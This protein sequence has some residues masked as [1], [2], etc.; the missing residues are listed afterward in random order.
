MRN[1]RLQLLILFAAGMGAAQFRESG[2]P[3]L[4]AH[5]EL[6]TVPQMPAR[7]YLFK[8]GRPFRL[9][10]VGA[11]LP[12]R[13]DLFYRERLWRAAADPETL[14]VT[15]N[16]QSHFFLLKGRATF[17]LPAGHYRVEAYRGLFYVPARAEFDI[18]AGE[19][20]RVPLKMENWA[21]AARD[22]W[23]SGDDHIHLTRSPEDN[24]IFLGWL[25]A[26]DLTVANFLQLQRQMDAAVQYGFGPEGQATRGGRYTIR[27]GQ[28]SRA[29]YFGHV[30]LLGGRE[31][32]RPVSVGTMYANTPEMSWFPTTLFAR[33]RKAGAT[34]GYAHFS[35]SMPHSTLPMDLAA[36][37]IDFLEVFQFGV[38]KTAEWYQLL[39]AGLRA[40]GIAGSD[41]PVPL[42]NSKQWPRWIPLLGPERTLVKA[43]PKPDPYTAWA[44]GREGRQR[45]RDERAAGRDHGQRRA[46]RGQGDREF[47]PPA[48]APGD[49]AQRRGGR[50]GGW[51]RKTHIAG[52]LGALGAGR[53]LL[54]G[55]AGD[56]TQRTG[57]ARDS[58]PYE[59]RCTWGSPPPWGM[60]AAPWRRNGKR[61]WSGTAQP[62][63]CFPAK[64]PGASSSRRVR[65]RCGCCRDSGPG[66]PRPGGSEL[67]AHPG[68]ILHERSSYETRRCTGR[69]PRYDIRARRGLPDP[70]GFHRHQC[71]GDA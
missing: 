9:S 59:S 39:N 67:S 33:G 22:Q 51:G 12:L 1:R 48:G 20:R 62:A 16:D 28:E 18:A 26:E 50:A 27:P 42:N 61:S 21:G 15:C 41:F 43:A 31:I 30:N 25:Q 45:H 53:E 7:V 70:G 32:L 13:V 44:E 52:G 69:S 54:G 66:R 55:R 4:A 37:T 19:T 71:E 47:L 10:P 40:T 6:A 38:L 65:R 11:V 68:R 58:G 60:H 5:L 64:R 34:V 49:C 8:D 57:R 14:E 23:L 36:G 29:Q 46:N 2:L 24:D 63:W 56:R 3:Q 35:G 17:D